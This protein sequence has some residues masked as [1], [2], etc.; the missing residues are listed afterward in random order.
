MTSEEVQAIVVER[1]R[2]VM[3]L[4]GPGLPR[5]TTATDW[6][7]VRFEDDL[8]AD[9][10]DVVEIVEGV[11]RELRRRGLAVSVADAELV[12]LVTVGDAVDAFLSRRGAP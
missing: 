6:R 10:L 7:G 3:G 2:A 11:E 8:H 5:R 9:S 4:E 12:D 1:V